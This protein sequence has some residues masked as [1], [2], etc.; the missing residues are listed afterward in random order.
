MTAKHTS[1]DHIITEH[2]PVLPQFQF[3]GNT[4]QIHYCFCYGYRYL[5]TPSMVTSVCTNSWWATTVSGMIGSFDHNMEDSN[6]MSRWCWSWRKQQSEKYESVCKP[7]AEEPSLSQMTGRLK[8]YHLVAWSSGQLPI[9]ARG[10]GD[11]SKVSIYLKTKIVRMNSYSAMG[12]GIK[13]NQLS[14]GIE[15]KLLTTEDKS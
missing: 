8:G 9:T 4:M 10:L 3:C 6:S 14:A 1:L 13:T 15:G 7:V 12:R 5:I 2:H 11:H